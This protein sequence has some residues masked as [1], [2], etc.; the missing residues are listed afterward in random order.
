MK[1]HLPQ[2]LRSALLAAIAVAF[3]SAAESAPAVYSNTIANEPYQATSAKTGEFTAIKHDLLVDAKSQDW[4]LEVKG[5][6]IGPRGT[7][8]KRTYI[9]GIGE[10][11]TTGNDSSWK[12]EAEHPF[13]FNV[14]ILPDSDVVLN[15][16]T[17]KDKNKDYKLKNLSKTDW[18]VVD[19]ISFFISYNA[20]EDAVSIIG[21]TVTIGGKTYN[22]SS[23]YELDYDL[24]STFFSERTSEDAMLAMVA[25]EGSTLS[26]KLYTYGSAPGWLIFGKTDVNG[27]YEDK[28]STGS[29]TRTIQSGDAIQFLGSSGI[30]YTNT[31]YTLSNTVSVSRN[32]Q[33]FTDDLAMGYGAAAG[34]TLTITAATNAI[35]NAS[36]EAL[37]PTLN[38]I[39]DGTVKLQYD[40]ANTGNLS[41]VSVNIADSATL[42]INCDDA[43]QINLSKGTFSKNASIVKTGDASNGSWLMIDTGDKATT[44]NKLINDDGDLEIFGTGSLNTTLLQG[45]SVE[46]TGG[47]TAQTTNIVAGT[48][49]V[50]ID[51]LSKVSVSSNLT[52]QGAVET[53]GSL[54]VGKILTA[55]SVTANGNG[56]IRAAEIQASTVTAGGVTITASDATKSVL[57][58]NVSASS[59]GIGADKLALS[60]ITVAGKAI[61]TSVTSSN[62]III[63]DEAMEATEKLTA[64]S[65]ILQGSYALAAKELIVDSLTDNTTTIQGSTGTAASLKNIS[66]YTATDNI[67]TISAASITAASVAIGEN[68]Q[69]IGAAVTTQ[70]EVS[71]AQGS[72][73][74]NASIDA[75]T[76]LDIGANGKLDNVSINTQG[77]TTLGNSAALRNVVLESGGL[78]NGSNVSLDNLTIVTDG[79]G[80]AQTTTDFG[81]TSGAAVQITNDVDSVQIS[82]KLDG[83]NLE[84]SKLTINAEGLVFNEGQEATY[85]FIKGNSLDYTYDEQRDQINIGSYV[86]AEITTD[87]NGN[88]QV[89]GTKDSAG[90][91]QALADTHNR[92][93]AIKAMD[94][95]LGNTPALATRAATAKSPLQEIHEYV[96]HVMRYSETD[97]KN[98]LSAASGASLAALADTQRRGL[99]DVQDN[100]RNRI[101]QMGGGTSAGLTTDWEYVGLQAWAQADGGLASTS[102]SGDEW[103]YDYD[104]MGATV[105]ANID[106]TANTVIGM[107]FSASYGEITVDDST[108]HAKGNNDAQYISFFARHNKERWVQM[109]IFTYGMNEMDMER[110]VLGYNAKGDTK[111]E[112]FS[113]YYELGYTL[114]IDYEYEHI[115]Q[116]LVSVS[117]TSASVD[118]FEEAGSIGNAGINYANNS[119][120]YGQV[121]IGA[122]YQGVLYETVHERNAVV[123][124]RALITHDFGDTTD[125]AS[126]ALA[127]SK[128][129]TVKGADSSG[130]GFKIGAGLSIPVE[131]HTTLYADVDYT[132]APDYSGFRGNIGVRYDF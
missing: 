33:D 112:T 53:S 128:E 100:L 102:G 91:K 106:L 131:Q 62:Q 89:V 42:E 108:D 4:V 1:P 114:G 83:N 31:D 113:A 65:L 16:R 129:Y 25:A 105:G 35:N 77:G 47:V 48:N 6:N 51:P 110:S 121:A 17:R 122:R 71:I 87:A 30:L 126:V 9:I 56:S 7:D 3:P 116:P 69:L 132:S 90:I 76:T 13:S 74:Q 52:A 104:T 93:E 44:L 60:N 75:G 26:T 78:K 34:T 70:A 8:P 64:Q 92:T 107:S 124:A 50:T 97:R 115:V 101:I 86:H 40:S 111:G 117:F 24:P 43:G 49:G 2:R 80:N 14:M 61:G 68:T 82:G 46:I 81:G 23:H 28:V 22:L 57:V 5:T 84:I 10:V 79:S 11:T 32:L 54:S 127:G 72:S 73:V 95:A 96:G 58:G 45:K 55:S 59:L 119:Y 99:R 85:A 41:N 109:F 118:S 20:A 37:V 66:I 27:T 15:L 125:E 67:R 63:T 103:G 29:S 94:E 98:V 36:G 19:D 120:F 88:I 123:E 38:I 21:S 12:N 130:M 39:G 18:T